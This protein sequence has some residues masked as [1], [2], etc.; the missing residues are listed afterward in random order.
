MTGGG[1]QATKDKGHE[2]YQP[3]YEPTGGDG[4]SEPTIQIRHVVHSLRLGVPFFDVVRLGANG[5]LGCKHD[6]LRFVGHS[7][8]TGLVHRFLK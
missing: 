8:V 3:Q 4:S 2:C 6:I 5:L 7:A 1:H